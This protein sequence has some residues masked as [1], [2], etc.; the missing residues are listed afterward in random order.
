MQVCWNLTNLCNRDCVYCFRELNERQLKLHQNLSVIDKLNSMGGERITYC[1]GEPLLYPNL[2]ELMKYSK[3]LGMTNNL[4]TNG[5]LLTEKNLD[6]YLLYVDKITFSIDSPSDYVNQATGRGKHYYEHIKGLLPIIHERYP[7]LV[8]EINSVVTRESIKEVDYMFETI[9]G[10]LSFYGIKKWKIS[11]FCPL[12][13]RAKE[14][15]NLF[16]LPDR[17]FDAIKNKYDGQKAMFEISV[18]DYSDIN[19]N[20]IV[21]PKGALKSSQGTEE[22]LIVDSILDTPVDEITKA[23]RLGGYHV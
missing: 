5:S 22:T 18:R 17:V 21:S 2:I 20:I 1:G 10:E 7:D 13:G 23:L 4:I 14:R 11:R 3:C 16:S 6:S 8:I 12:R 9:A 15:E 19:E